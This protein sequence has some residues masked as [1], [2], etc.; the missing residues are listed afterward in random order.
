ML[1]GLSACVPS[2]VE[3]VNEKLTTTL[4]TSVQKNLV[5]NNTLK[6]VANWTISCKPSL[7]P[8]SFKKLGSDDFQFVLEK[9]DQGNCQHDG[10]DYWE[11]KNK[12]YDFS[13]RQE[14]LSMLPGDGEYLF[15]AKVHVQNLSGPALR[16]TIFQ[17]HDTGK[18]DARQPPATYLAVN[19]RG[20]F[21]LSR[22]DT[23]R[24]P[25]AKSC[26]TSGIWLRHL[27]KEPFQLTVR[28]KIKDK[29]VWADYYINDA[30]LISAENKIW[31][32]PFVKIGIYRINAL[33]KTIQTYRDVALVKVV[34]PK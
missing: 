11:G 13:E 5:S 31:G 4:P 33:G 1:L 15:S 17:I 26:K 25:K 27:P 30:H 19:E 20:R 14:I 28:F 12:I 24:G 32:R 29:N 10:K 34:Q 2:D 6:N 8:Y 21:R 3:Y 7:T 9:G 22:C 18:G 16:S 23:A